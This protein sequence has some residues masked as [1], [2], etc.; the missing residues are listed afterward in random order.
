MALV[1][2]HSPS[3]VFAFY[4]PVLAAELCDPGK[5]SI[6]AGV[7]PAAVHFL[8]LSLGLYQT[9]LAVFCMVLLAYFLVLLFQNGEK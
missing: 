3:L 1:S 4:L 9:N 8:A 5:I 2:H 7:A 6:A